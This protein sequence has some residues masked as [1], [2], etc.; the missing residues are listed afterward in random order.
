MQK[1]LA[2]L[3][4]KNRGDGKKVGKKGSQLEPYSKV[5]YHGEIKEEPFSCVLL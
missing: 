1:N 5:W 2:G 3:E 4:V